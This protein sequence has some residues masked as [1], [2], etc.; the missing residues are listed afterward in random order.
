MKNIF[1]LTLIL[2]IALL[3]SCGF[4]MG[5]NDNSD[6]DDD[7]T[8]P[9]LIQSSHL[10]YRGAFNVPGVSSTTGETFAWSGSGLAYNP[11]N[12]S[13]FMTGHDHY[14]MVGE[15]SIPEPLI[16]DDYE[17]LP[18]SQLLQPL[19]DVADGP[20]NALGVDGAAISDA[21]NNIKIGGLLVY[22]NYLYGTYYAYYEDATEADRSHFR[23][24][25][26]LAAT[27]DF[28]GMFKVGG[29][30]PGLVGGYM[31]HIPADMQDDFGAAVLTGNAC[32]PIISRSSLGPA[33]STL[34]PATLGHSGPATSVPLVYYNGDHPTL[35][36]YDNETEV[37]P[38]F[39]MSTKI[40][41]VIFPE[42]SKTVL[43]FGRT[44]LGI[45]EYGAGTD[46]LSMDG[47]Q[48]PGYD[49]YYVYDPASPLSKGTHAWP[50]TV[51]V[52]AYSTDDLLSVY[53]GDKEPWDVTPYS[54]WALDLPY[55][56]ETSTCLLGGAAYDPAKQRVYISFLRVNSERP[57]IHVYDLVF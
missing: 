29:L 43:F 15:I 18:E 3:F 53:N 17:V 19:V 21:N 31:A 14:Q 44:G 4:S 25:L 13:L 10:V 7:D 2:I 38:A 56:D 5:N 26:N 36:T 22:N 49:E 1:L 41:G 52:W 42:D 6:D 54:H 8:N 11:V 39:N 45:P 47:I 20:K 34:V 46:D 24:S 35:G 30:D 23:C 33:V 9:T 12:D 16:S 51:Y 57:V 50:Y 55:T 37:N 48:V 27:D 32:I 40:N 28:E